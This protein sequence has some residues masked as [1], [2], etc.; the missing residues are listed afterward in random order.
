MEEI[1]VEGILEK[2][3]KISFKEIKAKMLGTTNNKFTYLVSQEG[4]LNLIGLIAYFGGSFRTSYIKR[5][6]LEGNVMVI[7]TRNS[8][9]RFKLLEEDLVEELG[10]GVLFSLTLAELNFIEG[11]IA[12]MKLC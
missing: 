3:S 9:Y 4:N 2:F 10:Q 8:T 6:E 11:E 12:R 5:I 7:N 1:T